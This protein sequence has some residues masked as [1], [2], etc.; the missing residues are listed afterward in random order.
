MD[1]Y[2][3]YLDS[4]AWVCEVNLIGCSRI[5][6]YMRDNGHKIVDNPSNADFIIINSCGLTQGHIKKCMY[7]FKKY[8]SLKKENARIILFGCLIKINPELIDSLDCIKIDFNEGEKFDKI[9]SKKVKFIDVKPYCDSKTKKDLLG[10]KNPFH[11]TGIFP[12]LFSAILLLFSKKARI[13]YNRII[14]NISYK[15]RIF[16]EI[17][18]GCT[19]N[20]S[21]CVIK[22]ARGNISSRPIKDI[23]SDIE[24][25]N[26]SEKKLFLVA[27]DCGCYGI[28]LKTNLVSLLNE[29]NKNFPNLSIELNYLNPQWIERNS[30]EYIKL[31]RELNIDFV[32]IPVQN[33]SNK[34]LKNMNRRYN[35]ENVIKIVDKIKKVS[36]RTFIYSHFI[37]GYPGE[38]WIDYFKTLVCALHF[39]FPIGF[40]YSEHKGTVSS[41]LPHQKAKITI[42][43]RYVL[44]VIFMNFLMFKKLLSRI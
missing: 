44:F 39:D 36:P 8:N 15:N 32:V 40:E 30:D 20:C 38:K 13:N 7:L 21:Y 27:N 35:I 4:A 37:I 42:T 43:L 10:E 12:F 19:G 9:F 34:V 31:F 24:K 3:V 26:Y 6:R 23:L 16:V 5:H 41:S 1:C 14:N 29:V 11:R 33:G 2:D 25:I 17:S 28:D 18:M 22:K